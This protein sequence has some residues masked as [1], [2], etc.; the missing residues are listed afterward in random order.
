M[1]RPTTLHPALKQVPSSLRSPSFSPLSSALL[2]TVVWLSGFSWAALKCLQRV[3]V[4]IW[5]NNS[6]PRG[7]WDIWQRCHL[8]L[9]SCKPVLGWQTQSKSRY[10][11]WA[12]SAL[13]FSLFISPPHLLLWDDLVFVATPHAVGP[14]GFYGPLI[15]DWSNNPD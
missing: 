3:T 10:S 14:L 6:P 12:R 5:I 4:H 7:H 11:I 1:L 13:Y 2:S 15:N 8:Q 9:L